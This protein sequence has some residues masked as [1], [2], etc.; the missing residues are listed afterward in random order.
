MS[1]ATARAGDDPGYPR[2][3]SRPQAVR[4]DRGASRLNH[5]VYD[6]LKERLLDGRYA[7]GERLSAVELRTEFDVSKQPIMEALRRL[8]GDGLI[9][10]I[11]QVGSRVAT[12]QP[13][14]VGDFFV[15]F[16]GFEGSIAG[17]AA[18][19]RTAEQ[20]AELD[21][22]SQQIDALRSESDVATRSRG[23]RLWNRRFHEAIHLMAHSRIMA[24]TS[25]RMWDLSD[26]LIN[27]T[28]AAPNPLS[29]ALDE[30]HD[31]HERIR[32]AL[33]DGDQ[34]TARAEM[35]SH[36]VRTVDVIHENDEARGAS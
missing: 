32:A 1:S 35:E 26:F 33:H 22:I 20:M 28:G 18:T 5:A 23:Y 31:D 29:S 16:G 13:H 3:V 36:I 25:R 4:L 8:S 30:R 7:A 27:T 6:Q 9:D 19:R 10:I 24:E 11:P 17:I 15:M 14:E 2:R 34:P 21:M 12:Y